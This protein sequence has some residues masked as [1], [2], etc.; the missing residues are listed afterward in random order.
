[1]VIVSKFSLGDIISP[2]SGVVPAEDPK[3][4][5]NFLIYPFGFSIRLGVVGGGEGEV[6]FQEF[7]EFSSEGGSTLGASVRD[8]FVIEAEAEVYFVEEE[9]SDAFGSDVFLCRAENHPLSK[10]MVDHDQKGIEAGG[11][12][13]VSDKVTGDLL[14]G[15]GCG[16]ANGGER[17]D[18]RV[19]VGLVLLAG[20]TAFD[21]LADVGGQA[22]PPE[23]GRNK[24][25]GFEITWMA[26]TVVVMAMLQN[27]VLEGVVIWDIDAALIG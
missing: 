20:C 24:L 18:G 6:V 5:L 8:D 11:R 9:C 10:P 12:G 1:M 14:E 21:I 2:R 25:S 16:G 15:A 27:S 19:G 26:G 4:H 3:V 22:R 23:L 13:K 7:P 17:W